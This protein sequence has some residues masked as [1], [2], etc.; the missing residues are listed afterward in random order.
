MRSARVAAAL[1]VLLLVGCTSAPTT[2][3][4]AS[5]TA[6]PAMPVAPALSPL[7]PGSPLAVLDTPTPTFSPTP[8]AEPSSPLPDT[9]DGFTAYKKEAVNGGVTVHYRDD[10]TRTKSFTAAVVPSK[11]T[12]AELESVLPGA[13][14]VGKAWCAVDVDDPKLNDC[15]AKVGV[16]RGVVVIG[17]GLPLAEL[18]QLTTDLAAAV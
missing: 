18:G 16:T 12:D 1:S 2:T 15:I 3:S 8:T 17:E 10:A 4:P 7:A 9:V 14:R 6:H 13:I 5:T 11:K